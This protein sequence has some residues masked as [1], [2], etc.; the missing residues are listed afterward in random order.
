MSWGSG[1][2]VIVVLVVIIS[3]VNNVSGEDMRIIIDNVEER[4]GIC[5]RERY[6]ASIDQGTD[7]TTVFIIRISSQKMLFLFETRLWVYTQ[8]RQR[9]SEFHEEVTG[10]GMVICH[11]AAI[12]LPFESGIWCTT[13]SALSSTILG[14]TETTTAT[15]TGGK[16]ATATIAKGTTKGRLTHTIKRSTV[17][18]E[19]WNVIILVE[20]KDGTN[21]GIRA[22][23]MLVPLLVSCRR[24]VG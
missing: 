23:A 24:R 6:E 11:S 14:A 20:V 12:A 22:L 3:R 9:L 16:V 2:F 15:A 19:R 21:A 4:I 1:S 17:V 13:T 18:V 5:T 7:V 8:I 10:V